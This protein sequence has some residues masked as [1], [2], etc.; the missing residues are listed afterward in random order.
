MYELIIRIQNPAFD[1]VEKK[2]IMLPEADAKAIWQEAK[3]E[4][5]TVEF[6]YEGIDYMLS[7]SDI[8]VNLP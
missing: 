5:K 8:L 7:P 3:V 1:G 6:S 2:A 4:K